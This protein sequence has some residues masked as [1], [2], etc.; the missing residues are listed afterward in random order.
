MLR[1]K[2]CLIHRESSYLYIQLLYHEEISQSRLRTEEE[3][4]R[5][6]KDVLVTALAYD[7]LPRLDIRKS[8]LFT[9]HTHSLAR[10]ISNEPY[11]KKKVAKR[12][13]GRVT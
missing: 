4:R 8:Y 13:D 3:R 1:W 6:S 7:R 5:A 10:E 9:K 12:Y 2:V 11:Q